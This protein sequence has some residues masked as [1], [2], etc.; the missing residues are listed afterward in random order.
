[1]T[2]SELR[3]KL[4]TLDP[5]SRVLICRESETG[6]ELFEISD[7]SLGRRSLRANSGA[8]GTVFKLCIIESFG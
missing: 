5:N 3:K 2:V 1:M 7:A 8:R 4:E 6:V